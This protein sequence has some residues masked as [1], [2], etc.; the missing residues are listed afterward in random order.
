MTV[1]SSP[2]GIPAESR[3][4]RETALKARQKTLLRL[5]HDV[6]MCS[7]SG[8]DQLSQQLKRDKFCNEW[9][10]ALFCGYPKLLYFFAWKPNLFL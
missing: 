7:R 1:H 8:Q 4:Y 9:T 6:S 5:S 3:E 2:R 10:N